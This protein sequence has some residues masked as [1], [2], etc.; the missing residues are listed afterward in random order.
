MTEDEKAKAKARAIKRLKKKLSSDPEVSQRMRCVTAGSVGA[1]FYHR[2]IDLADL[3]LTDMTEDEIEA[4]RT[5][6]AAAAIA[7]L[8]ETE[9]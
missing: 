8:G 6:Y 2:G 9:S 3:D 7:S 1:Q 5:G 4:L